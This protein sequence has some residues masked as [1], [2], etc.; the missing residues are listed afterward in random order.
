M[1]DNDL[2]NKLKEVFNVLDDTVIIY[3][4]DSK[5]KD[6][7][8]LV[9]M[10]KDVE[11]TSEFIKLNFTNISKDIPCF[12]IGNSNLNFI[13]IPNGHEFSSLILAIL[14][15]NFKGKMP[16]D[17]LIKRIKNLNDN[18]DLKTFISL[19]CENCP[20][21]VQS[22]NLISILH[23]NL[24]HTMIDG[25]YT[26]EE[27]EKLNIQGVP[28]VI[29]GSKLVLAGKQSLNDIVIKLEEQ[30]GSKK[31]LE[32]QELG[33]YE[34]AIV[35]GGPAGTS[36]AIYSAR[37]GLKTVLISENIG[38]QVKDT[39]GIENLI[40]TKY[41]EGGDLSFNLRKHLEDY[42]IK[43]LENRRVEHIKTNGSLKEIL[44]NTNEQLK[45]KSIILATG[46]KW[47]KLNI[48]GE[49]EFL[50]KG[51]AFCPTCDGP[52]YKNKNVVVVGGGNSGVEAAIDL[53]GIVNSVTII[54]YDREL[55][56]D[57]LLIKK[58]QEINNINFLTNIE[59]KE[60]IGEQKV[61]S[62][63]YVDR[64]TNKE[65]ILETEGVFIQIG[66]IPNTDFLKEIVSLNKYGEI[67]IDDKCRTNQDYIYAAGD[68]TTV[69]Y[70]Q[71]VISMGEGSKAALTAFEDLKINN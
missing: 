54:E 6:Q 57:S 11:S 33:E 49:K 7:L 58:A 63:K 65:E 32:H 40:S 62:I 18:I 71:I 70:K 14:N 31:Q 46:A 25:Q 53:S 3:V 19:T 61:K 21:V 15:Y 10:L 51:V 44:L 1:L 35:G 41:I 9:A 30:F 59:T 64:D 55:K 52:F 47:R 66:L 17:I 56:A 5:H 22:L 69:P 24:K 34:V 27:I 50:G 2:L 8:D 67:I 4:D 16:D 20:E 39:K 68:V 42:N 43:I 37:K 13:G 60:I 36:S 45:T 26:Q 48:P 29:S 23:G 12:S 28:S 38:G